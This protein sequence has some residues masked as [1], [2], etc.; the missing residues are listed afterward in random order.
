MRLNESIDLELPSGTEDKKI[1]EI[2]INAGSRGLQGIQGDRGQ[3]GN[4]YTPEIGNTTTLPPGSPATAT[5]NIDN[6]TAY[7]NFG[8]P[9]GLKGDKGD[10]GDTTFTTF[11]VVD[12]KLIAYYSRENTDYEFQLNGNKL[13]VVLSE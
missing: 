5:L 9:E 7:Y 1:I 13:E 12:G 8:I 11:D 6:N 2:E 4:T 10:T 3:D